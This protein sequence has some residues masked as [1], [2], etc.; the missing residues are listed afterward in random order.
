MSPSTTKLPVIENSA[1]EKPTAKKPTC[2]RCEVLPRGA[3]ERHPNIDGSIWGYLSQILTRL[4]QIRFYVPNLIHGD[5]KLHLH[6]IQ[7]SWS[8]KQSMLNCGS[9]GH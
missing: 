3:T 8:I 7:N 5:F 9:M 6:Y 4:F 1:L 2:V